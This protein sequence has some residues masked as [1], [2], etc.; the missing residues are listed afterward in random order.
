[1][2]A[3]LFRNF[4]YFKMFDN[5]YYQKA[6]SL[7]CDFDFIVKLFLLKGW[8]TPI[9]CIEQAPALDVIGIGLSDGHIILHNLKCDKTIMDFY[10]DYGLVTNIAF[11]TDGIPIM[12]TASP[13]GHL[14][15]WD[16]EKKA[17]AHQLLNAHDQSV[18]GMQFLEN[19]PLLITSSPDNTLKLWIFDM[20]DG[21]PRL[22][23]IREGHSAPPSMIRFY[24]ADNLLSSG[25][26]KF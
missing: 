23:R 19:E 17:V 25:I 20:S 9:T 7:F 26:I 18:T 24:D 2:S 6:N 14:V 5:F 11:R 15:F 16:L 3:N 22:L 4:D 1:M 12:A 8:Q 13:N 10:Q 21:G